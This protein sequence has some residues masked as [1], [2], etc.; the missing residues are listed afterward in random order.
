CRRR[1]TASA[2][3]PAAGCP[4]PSRAPARATGSAWP[5]PTATGC[6][7]SSPP[8][9]VTAPPATC[10]RDGRIPPART[11]SSVAWTRTA[12]R[13]AESPLP[14]SACQPHPG[15]GVVA[16]ALPGARLA[17]DARLD[18]LRAQRVRYQGQVDAQAQVAAERGLPVVP[19]AED[20]GLLAV[21]AERIVQAQRLQPHQRLALGGRSQDVAL[22]PQ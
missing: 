7:R 8:T 3:R 15:R 10:R 18:R 12:T 4:W 14:A 22:V 21:Q 2:R 1:W 13:A 9:A 6:A 20:A 16:G 17:V 11:A 5:A 19:P